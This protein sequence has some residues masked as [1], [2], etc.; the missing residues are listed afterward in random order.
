MVNAFRYGFL[1]I[2]DVSVP[3]AFLIMVTLV[4]GL[5]LTALI[6]M[7]RGVGIRE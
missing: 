5:F 2:S 1:G 6:L 3:W 4:T 7:N